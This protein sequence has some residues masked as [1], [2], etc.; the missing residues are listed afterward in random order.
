MISPKDRGSRDSLLYWRQTIFVSL[1]LTI[2]TLGLFASLSGAFQFLKEE[3]LPMAIVVILYYLIFFIIAFVRTISYQIRIMFL[4]IS[5]YIIGIS[6]LISTGPFGAGLLYLCA[7]YIYLSINI[8]RKHFFLFSILNIFS[9]LLLSFFYQTGYLDEYRISE[10]GSTWWIILI[11]LIFINIFITRMVGIFLYGMERRFIKERRAN[12]TL[13]R[14]RDRN[15]KQIRLLK[16][17]RQIG[18]CLSDKRLEMSERLNILLKNLH[19]E[20]SIDACALTF[21]NRNTGDSSYLSSSPDTPIN[22]PF[23]IPSFSGPYLMRDHQN[24]RDLKDSTAMMRQ[25]KQGQI[26]FGSHFYSAEQK[27]FLELLLKEQPDPSELEYIQMNLFQ[28]SG[29]ITNE[30][31]FHQL[32]ESRD[33]LELSYDEILK[34]W[35]KILELRDIETKG[36]SHRVV[37]L[38]VNL[39][40]LLELSEKEIIHL[41]RGAFLHDIGKLGIPDS[42][43][44]KEGPLNTEEWDI[45][46]KHPQIGKESVQNIPFLKPALDVIYHH[47][48]H[49]D[50]SGYPAGLEAEAI[51]LTA[52]IFTH[53]D[54]FDALISDRP[55]RRA[56][57]KKDA[58][59]S[60]ISEKGQIFDPEILDIF[61]KNIEIIITDT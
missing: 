32:E 12:K 2:L 7:S 43:L 48:E 47:H 53:A 15:N 41:Q 18:N 37:D 35:A 33:T 60:M 1:L 24:R 28:L 14:M 16:S 21:V 26:Y 20:L 9:L 61:I 42:I 5:L 6:L 34:A 25:L 11:N 13:R 4:D 49:W 31:L 40:K 8:S 59:A 17:L 44:H 50:G 51:P 46:R 57:T 19:T 54:V 36:H 10:Y 55:Y 3:N 58:I 45:M 52:R 22:G 23:P 38:S 56:L 27:G 39:A 30:Q 29:A